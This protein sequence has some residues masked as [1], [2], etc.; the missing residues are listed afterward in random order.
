M[1]KVIHSAEVCTTCFNKIAPIIVKRMLGLGSLMDCE[2]VKM[3][4]TRGGPRNLYN[5]TI[6]RFAITAHIIHITKTKHAT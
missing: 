6:I 2:V 5:N 4:L 1:D 3:Y